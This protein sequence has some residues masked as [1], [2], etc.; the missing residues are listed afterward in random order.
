M[1]PANLA[2]TTWATVTN[3][4]PRCTAWTSSTETCITST[5]RNGRSKRTTRTTPAFRAKFGPRGV[6]DCK[7]SDNDD[8]TVDPRFGKVGKQVCTDTGPLTKKRMQII[9]D[10]IDARAV[11]F[12]ERQNKICKP[13]FVW[14]NFTHMHFRT[15]T[16]VESL[17]QS[18][19][20]QSAYHD[21]MIDH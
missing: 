5:P 7:A 3:T 11:D 10:D 17:G 13:A 19:R 6:L 4:C 18:G 9:Y 20:W 12:I 15:H 1:R 2:R 14:V 16:K 8:P 21:T